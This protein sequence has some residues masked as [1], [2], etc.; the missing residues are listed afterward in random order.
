METEADSEEAGAWIEG[1]SEEVG[2]EDLGAHLDLLWSKWEAE[3]AGVEDQERWTSKA[4]GGG[5]EWR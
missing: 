4:W 2:E 1:A 3:A 5:S